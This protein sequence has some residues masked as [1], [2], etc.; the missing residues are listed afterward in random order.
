MLIVPVIPLP[1]VAVAVIVTEPAATPVTT[2]FPFIV[3]I[4]SSP[5]DHFTVLLVAFSGVI[6]AVSCNVSFVL[7]LVAPSAAV[8]AI[9]VT[10]FQESS[11]V[12]FTP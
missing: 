5:E 9:P 7:T 12:T 6:V 2:P 10:L 4:V 1:S 3:A 11:F 8:T